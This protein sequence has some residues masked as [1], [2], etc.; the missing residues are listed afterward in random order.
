LMISVK[1]LA[2]EF[3]LAMGGG[4]GGAVDSTARKIEASVPNMVNDL[5]RRIS[6]LLARTRERE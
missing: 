6:R 2:L 1:I 3:L 5:G 4:T